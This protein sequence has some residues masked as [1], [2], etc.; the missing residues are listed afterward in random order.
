[1][2]Y[3][4]SRH[5]AW[6]ATC[7]S[8]L[9]TE[10][11]LIEWSDNGW[12]AIMI[13]GASLNL[14]SSPLCE[15]PPNDIDR[16]P[17]CN[18]KRTICTRGY[19]QREYTQISS[20]LVHHVCCTNWAKLEVSTFEIWLLKCDVPGSEGSME[21]G[22][23]SR[24]RTHYLLFRLTSDTQYTIRKNQGVKS[25]GFSVLHVERK[26]RNLDTS[27]LKSTF[28]LLNDPKWFVRFSSRIRKWY[29]EY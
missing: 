29:S 3:A 9:S 19:L 27:A 12:S 21:Y 23:A 28:Y 6:P 20:F 14:A 26:T 10:P 16:S 2:G 1:M 22:W 18:M 13:C 11:Y 15:K 25:H 8:T 24:R 5:I 17:W 4:D 7:L